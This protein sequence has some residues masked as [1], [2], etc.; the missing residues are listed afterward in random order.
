MATLVLETYS[1]DLRRLGAAAEGDALRAAGLLREVNGIG[2][3]GSAVFLREVQAVWPW[4]RPCLDIRA[5][6]GASRVGLPTDPGELARLV[7]PDE[8]ARFAAGLVRVSLLSRNE[9]PLPDD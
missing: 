3:T 7:P 6:G 5:T 4:L 2:P 8:L 9:R 1:G